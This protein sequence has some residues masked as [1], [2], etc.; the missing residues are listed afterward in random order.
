MFPAQKRLRLHGIHCLAKQLEAIFGWGNKGND[1]IHCGTRAQ[2][3][4]ISMVGYPQLRGSIT[5]ENRSPDVR[6]P[7]CNS[8]K[9]ARSFATQKKNPTVQR[10]VSPLGTL[11]NEYLAITSIRVIF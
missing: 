2:A 9:S 8:T 6:T 3:L 7:A 5:F 10:R 11:F 1:W 4:L